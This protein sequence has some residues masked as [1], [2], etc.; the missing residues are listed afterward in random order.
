MSKSTKLN[1][2]IFYFR[3]GMICDHDCNRNTDTKTD[4]YTETDK[5]L[6]IGERNFADL[7][8][9]TIALIEL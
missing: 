9:K 8:N 3:Q 1:Y 2:F 4:R 6:A 7:P 5:P